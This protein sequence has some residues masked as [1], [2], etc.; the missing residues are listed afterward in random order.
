MTDIP[1][2]KE[3]P[4]AYGEAAELSPL[5]RRVIAE[6]PGPFTFT[7]TGTYLVGR[8][9]ASELALIDPGPDDVRHL[10]AVRKAAGP[11]RISRIFVTHAHRDHCA[12]ARLFA[13]AFGARVFAAGTALPPPEAQ[14]RTAVEEG[15]DRG[16]APDESIAEGEAFAGEG[17]TLRAVAT[18][19]HLPDHL[20]FA[21]EE[22]GALFTGDHMMGWSTTVIAPPDG[23]MAD[24]Y[25]SLEKLLLRSDRIYYP[26]HGAPIARPA[27]F[28][29][30][31]RAHRR[32]RDGQILDRLRKGDRRIADMLPA[33]YAGLD[34]RLEG[35]A[36]LNLLAHLIRLV[37]I[38]AV[39]TEGAPAL[40]SRYRLKRGIEV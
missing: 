25:L 21:L 27:A 9:G 29:R 10:D 31:V 3:F 26:T 5:V 4:F 16:F 35:A 15:V 20:C 12:G 38:G 24:Y 14:A 36:S 34:L 19:G 7:G 11:G 40:A 30:A 32:M 2:V 39:E 1:F 22:E 18:P 23:R 17:W 6:N 28:V 37:D 8:P 33:I 13:E